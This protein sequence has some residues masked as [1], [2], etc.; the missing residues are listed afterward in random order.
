MDQQVIGTVG[1]ALITGIFV[2]AIVY[3]WYKFLTDKKE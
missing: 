3:G 1:L 2:C